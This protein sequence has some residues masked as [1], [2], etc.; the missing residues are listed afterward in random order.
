MKIEA[1]YKP[2]SKSGI[3]D[4]ILPPFRYTLLRHSSLTK[5]I[6]SK[7]VFSRN[8]ALPRGRGYPFH[9]PSANPT[10]KLEANGRRA[11][12]VERKAAI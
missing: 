6:M 7:M 10:A 11:T 2:N 9:I 12:A 4:I 3:S 5:L 1:F 8:E